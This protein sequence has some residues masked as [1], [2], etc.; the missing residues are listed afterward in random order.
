VPAP[1]LFGHRKVAGKDKRWR[2][3]VTL[4]AAM[5]RAARERGKGTGRFR[6]SPRSCR[7]GRQ[8]QGWSRAMTWPTTGVLEDAVDELERE[9]FQLIPSAWKT[10]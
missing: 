3:L 1:L 9:P 8:G 4:D 6:R 5:I 7:G 10:N 2:R